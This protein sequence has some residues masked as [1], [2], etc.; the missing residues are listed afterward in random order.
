[1]AAT[2]RM[3][4]FL[5]STDD[6]SG[7]VS[8]DRDLEPC[9]DFA[10]NLR[11]T[12]LTNQATHWTIPTRTF[13]PHLQSRCHWTF[14]RLL[15]KNH[16]LTSDRINKHPK[17]HRTS[18]TGFPHPVRDII[19]TNI[20]KHRSN[21]FKTARDIISTPP[22]WSSQEFIQNQMSDIFRNLSMHNQFW[23]RLS[24]RMARFRRGY[25]GWGRYSVI[26]LR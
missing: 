26:G 23:G 17:Y 7:Q 20:D 8:P 14:T 19:S 5:F 6:G 15:I 16:F 12:W 3:N 10:K 18:L 24:P 4:H 21:L 9:Q 11:T 25:E 2:F 22:P 13:L 1:M